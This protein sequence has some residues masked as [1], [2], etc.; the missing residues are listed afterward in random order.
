MGETSRE[1][2]IREVFEETHL[3]ILPQKLLYIHEFVQ[4]PY[5]AMEFY[6]LSEIISGE[7]TIGSDPELKPDNQQI[8][9]CE[10]IGL[11][12][13]KSMPLYP[14]FLQDEIQKLNL[15]SISS[16]KHFISS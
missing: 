2:V 8:K 10:F 15:E 16:V 14:T 4:P 3:K 6:Y 12:E 7:V 11:T 13:L 9:G 1:A 5:Q